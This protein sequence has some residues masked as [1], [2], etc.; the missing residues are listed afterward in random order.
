MNE[1]ITESHK[2]SD[3]NSSI[4]DLIEN[5]NK[6]DN[7][8]EDQS[9]QKKSSTIVKYPND[10][11]KEGFFSG[12]NFDY[13]AIRRLSKRKSTYLRGFTLK[14]NKLRDIQIHSDEDKSEL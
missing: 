2:E 13:L 5:T 4:D 14:Q 1:T 11:Q 12:A 8:L 7:F 10:E 9:P 3:S 6:F